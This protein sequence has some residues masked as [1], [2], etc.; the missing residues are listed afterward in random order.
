MTEVVLTVVASAVAGVFGYFT[1]RG[2]HKKDVSI[3]D[4]QI[5][6]KEEKDFRHDLR[7]EIKIY[8]EEIALLRIEISSLREA[9]QLLHAENRVLACKVEE[10]TYELKRHRNAM[11]E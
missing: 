6:S 8:R 10:L 5:L 1:A 3:S 4:R 2:T 9:N 11:E 7:E